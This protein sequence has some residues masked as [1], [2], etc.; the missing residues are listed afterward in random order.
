MMCS[1]PSTPFTRIVVSSRS[2]PVV[3]NCSLWIDALSLPLRFLFPV[4]GLLIEAESRSS[5]PTS[6]PEVV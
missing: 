3:M 1:P 4:S 6:E 5:N 2:L